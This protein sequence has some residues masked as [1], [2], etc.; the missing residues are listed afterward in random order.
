ML[1]TFKNNSGVIL[2]GNKIDSFMRQGWEKVY[3]VNVKGDVFFVEF[4]KVIEVTK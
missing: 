4:W 3:K 2:K 1:V